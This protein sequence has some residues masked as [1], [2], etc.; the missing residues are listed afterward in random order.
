M[1]RRG[2]LCVVVGWGML[3]SAAFAEDAF[4]HVRVNDIEF[5][6]G[7]LPD[8]RAVQPDWRVRQRVIWTKPDVQLDEAG[9]AYLQRGDLWSSVFDWSRPDNLAS[10]HLAMRIPARRDVTGRLI[11][12]KPDGSGQVALTF[13]IP[14]IGRAHV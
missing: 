1:L 5:S 6:D 12:P 14:E 11:L 7:K 9:E 4:F 10:V 3:C 13:R 2:L 8:Y